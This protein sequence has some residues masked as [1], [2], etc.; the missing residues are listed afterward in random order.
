M[1]AG[2][3]RHRVQIQE[4]S[5][6]RDEFNQQLDVWTPAATVSAN[7]VGLSG[8]EYLS[9]SGEAAEATHRVEMRS[10]AGL[11]P[12]HRILFGARILDILYVSDIDNRGI[13]MHVLC[14][15]RMA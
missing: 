1:R 10:Y 15:E 11:T 7:I 8:R 4:R 2:K 9:R 6:A 13:E 12:A 5:N 3:L 14:K